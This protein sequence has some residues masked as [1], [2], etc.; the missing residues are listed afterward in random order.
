MQNNARKTSGKVH[1][2]VGI[3]DGLTRA[4]SEE[5]PAPGLRGTSRTAS[6]EKYSERNE[7]E[8]DNDDNDDDRVGFGDFEDAL[9]SN[10]ELTQ[11]FG[12]ASPSRVFST[13]KTGDEDVLPWG[14]RGE[15]EQGNT[16]VSETAPVQ[17]Q[18]TLN[19]FRHISFNTN[20]ASVD[21]LFPDPPSPLT[22]DPTGGWEIPDHP[23]N[24]SFTAISERK[25]WYRISRYGSMRKH[26]SG[27]DE[28]YHR[29]TWST[30][31]L[32][33]DTIKI[34]RR[35]MEQDSYAGKA[36]L[37]GTKRTGFFDWDSDAAPVRLDE[38]FQR[39]KPVTNHARTTSIP[40]NN[41]IKTALAE[42]RP[43]RNSTGISFAAE[44]Q[45]ASK[46]IIPA[47]DFGWNSEAKKG[48]LPKVS[49]GDG[50][51]LNLTAISVPLHHLSPI[52]T[53]SIEGDDDDWGEMVSSPRAA[54]EH[55][56]ATVSTISLPKT[57]AGNHRPTPQL[58]QSTSTINKPV[59]PKFPS[60]QATQPALSDPSLF[61]DISVL[62]EIRH[63]PSQGSVT[64][65]GTPNEST[66][67]DQKS[68]N[69][70]S[71]ATMPLGVT[72]TAPAPINW[73]ESGSQDD[74]IVH[75]I[76]QRLPDLSY[77]LR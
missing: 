52:Q 30:S 43:Y 72:A 25:A 8:G 75:N 58:L 68:T 17:S 46:P 12:Q 20:V 3:Y 74:I 4:A 18:N 44:L 69:K 71:S 77:M 16:T 1:E 7:M 15:G 24:D 36:T 9:A 66:I 31:Q 32:H 40:A 2:L 11:P 23:I 54:E 56:D 10:G 13:P 45:P 14:P 33:D 37:G 48:P 42:Q 65:C 22:N 60:T 47:P 49:S 55:V 29:V 62:V 59:E 67:A 50:Q 35:W 51:D 26:N 57:A 70:A 41:V 63:P 6:R 73:A 61:S 28:N 27:D 76:L 39:R 5:P 19:K 53:T 34:V 64:R 21:K 38:I